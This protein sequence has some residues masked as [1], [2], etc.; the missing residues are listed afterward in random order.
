[1]CHLNDAKISCYAQDVTIYNGVTGL[2]KSWTR[3]ACV[4]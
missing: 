3:G 4:S 1:V 2:E